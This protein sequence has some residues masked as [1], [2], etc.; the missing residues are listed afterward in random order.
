MDTKTMGSDGPVES[1]KP[2]P[3]PS[4]KSFGERPGMDPVHQLPVSLGT[5]SSFNPTT[6]P[7]RKKNHPK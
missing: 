4:S 5:R 1:Y 7:T 2:M 3:S 6:E